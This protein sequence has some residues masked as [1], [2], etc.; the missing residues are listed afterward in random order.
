MRDQRE[1]LI[2]SVHQIK[3]SVP[4][5]CATGMQDY[6]GGQVVATAVG[7]EAIIRN[8]N[9]GVVATEDTG[10]MITRLLG[11]GQTL[12]I[13]D[14]EG[15]VTQWEMSESNTLS[16]T[17]S[18]EHD[19]SVSVIASDLS[20]GTVFTSACDGTVF[21]WIQGSISSEI[22]P[23]GGDF[24]TAI[25][26]S[27]DALFISDSSGRVKVIDST[28]DSLCEYPTHD[29]YIL[30]LALVLEEQLW[31]SG[32]DRTV[33]VREIPS[34]NILKSETFASPVVCIDLVGDMV[35][36]W[37]QDGTLT[38]CSPL[39][40]QSSQPLQDVFPPPVSVVSVA[41]ADVRRVWTPSADGCITVWDVRCPD[42]PHILS[43]ILSSKRHA[44][45]LKHKESIT[46]DQHNAEGQEELL[47]EK[48]RV[49]ELE[50]T[51]KGLVTHCTELQES[52]L[53]SDRNLQELKN[54]EQS[55]IEALNAELT[56]C[57]EHT[58][59]VEADCARISKELSE[60]LSEAAELRTELAGERAR[61]SGENA[62]IQRRLET[63]SARDIN[64]ERTIQ[65]LRNE[66]KQ[67]RLQVEALEGIEEQAIEA[68]ELIEESQLSY[69]SSKI[70]LFMA[71]EFSQRCLLQSDESNRFSAILQ[72][73]VNESTFALQDDLR[74]LKVV[75]AALRQHLD[76]AHLE[77][78]EKD[79]T[80]A[81]LNKLL[82]LERRRRQWCE[83]E[84]SSHHMRNESQPRS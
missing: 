66:I 43:H 44:A 12:W 33:V 55:K 62:E 16:K 74:C 36:L 64:N 3:T 24:I 1:P 35:W 5:S 57:Y 76:T 63:A 56:G 69:Q 10:C 45:S 79:S 72:N 68:S 84:L 20:T 40:L 17:G 25:C 37:S 73:H 58:A 14:D 83:D 52:V 8:V 48:R 51:V 42:M 50:D 49:V 41:Q 26:A 38:T 80:I 28:T 75:D 82:D 4:Y 27:N 39:T 29:G 30:T 15:K 2:S 53:M 22:L 23:A 18:G 47:N 59:V 70:E 71:N 19:N 78:S 13:G 60:A 65:T 54:N 34:G 46:T 21:E 11:V 67:L 77:K 31:S 9:G 81:E 32:E 61:G 6:N 7:S